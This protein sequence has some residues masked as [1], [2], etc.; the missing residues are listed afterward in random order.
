LLCGLVLATFAAPAAQ[1][2]DDDLTFEQS[3]IRRLFGGNDKDIDYRER[4]PL[5]IPP[6]TELPAPASSDA[7]TGANWPH[8]PD[9]A[10]RKSAAAKGGP[11]IDIFERDSRPL[12]R[13]ELRRGTIRGA[14]SN[15]PVRTLSDGEMGRPLTPAELGD[16][17]SLLGGLISSAKPEKPVAFAGEPA[18]SRLVEPPAGYRTPAATQPYA[19]PASDR[20]WYKP[21]SW[22]D[23]GMERQ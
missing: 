11:A 1:A 6:S 10:R 13:D 18:R 22:F 5:V 23:Y 19:P 17:R 16:N 14:R 8:D 4:S 12:S 9:A 7:A 20:P 3:I 21:F 2:A 15:A